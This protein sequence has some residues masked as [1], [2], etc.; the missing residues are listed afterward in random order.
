[1]V[2]KRPLPE[3]AKLGPVGVADSDPAEREKPAAVES[4]ALVEEEEAHG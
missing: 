3:V 4:A 2:T 1:M